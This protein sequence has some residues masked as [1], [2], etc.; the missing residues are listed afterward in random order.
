[1]LFVKFRE[2]FSKAVLSGC[3]SQRLTRSFCCGLYIAF[4]PFPGA[5]T[6][7]MFVSKYFFNL[8]FPTLFIAT[9]INNPWT[10]IPFFSFDYAFGYWFTHSFLGWEP[11]WV[12]SLERVFGAGKICIWSFLIGGN[13]LGIAAA[14]M[15]YPLIHT[16]FDRFAAA[17]R[18]RDSQACV[19]QPAY[20]NYQKEDEYK[21]KEQAQQ[22]I[23][24]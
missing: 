6:V 17:I 18:L 4:S 7:M 2:I 1:M 15:C 9:S 12:I 14:V 19:V 10:M 24:G 23:E 8:H 11:S 3:S 5:H 21:P 13:I 20:K 22:R 16:F